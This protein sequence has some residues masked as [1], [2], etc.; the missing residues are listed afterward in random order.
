MAASSCHWE[1]SS[2]EKEVNSAPDSVSSRQEVSPSA[3]ISSRPLEMPLPEASS[4]ASWYSSGMD[5]KR[6]SLTTTIEDEY[7]PIPG[8]TMCGVV[9]D[10]PK[11]VRLARANE[12]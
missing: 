6:S 5:W 4:S 8:S 3:S 12:V 2:S 10:R 11:V 9:S 1:T 7:A